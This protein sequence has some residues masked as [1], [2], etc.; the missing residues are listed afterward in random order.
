MPLSK[1]GIV[2]NKSVSYKGELEDDDANT[3]RFN[4]YVKTRRDILCT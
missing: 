3:A 1:M 2:D 4:G